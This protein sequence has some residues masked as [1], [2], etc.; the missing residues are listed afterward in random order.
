MVR[1]I[2]AIYH[3]SKKLRESTV[4]PAHGVSTAAGTSKKSEFLRLKAQLD[5]ARLQSSILAGCC[6]F[7]AFFFYLY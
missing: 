4:P 1:L 2:L 6:H 5:Q 7:L 3:S